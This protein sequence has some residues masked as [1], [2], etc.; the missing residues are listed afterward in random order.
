MLSASVP[1]LPWH[2]PATC[3][4]SAI[5]IAAQ[6]LFKEY[7]EFSGSQRNC[8]QLVEIKTEITAL[9]L[10]T[11]LYLHVFNHRIWLDYFIVSYHSVCP[12]LWRPCSNQRGR[13]SQST[14]SFLTEDV[15]DSL[16]WP[17][18]SDARTA[19]PQVKI[20]AY[21]AHWSLLSKPVISFPS[22]K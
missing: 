20:K 17:A 11:Q 2:C 8:T 18:L 22:S 21:Y 13:V 19:P 5:E 9:S 3:V 4:L 16:T 7:W 10:N 15:R 12:F 6:L 1:T 14:S